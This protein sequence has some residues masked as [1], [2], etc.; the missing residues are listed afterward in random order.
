MGVLVVAESW[1]VQPRNSSCGPPKK[2]WPMG[3]FHGPL[4]CHVPAA[5]EENGAGDEEDSGP[6]W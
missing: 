1:A 6:R 2:M 5:E 4:A 3:R